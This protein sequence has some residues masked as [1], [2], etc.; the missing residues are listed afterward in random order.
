MKIAFYDTH[1]YEKRVFEE[2]NKGF[3]FDITFFDFHLNED[4]Y[5]TAK[6]FDAVCVF[7]NDVVNQ[8]VIKKLSDCKVKIIA[9]RC[10]GFNNVDLGS[11]TRNGISVVRVPSY[12]PHAIAE[13][14]VGLM[15]SL[16]RK[17][18]Q[19]YIRT[20][21]ANFS[22]EGLVGKELYQKTV[23]IIGT[24]KIGKIV[25]L[26][27]QSFGCNV[28]LYDIYQ[29]FSWADKYNLTY[30][31]LQEVLT[32]SDIITLHCP[33]TE[34][35]KHI[36]NSASINLLKYNC[37]LINTSRGALIDTM[38]LIN[39]LKLKKIAGAALDVYEEESAFFF[40]DWS[41]EILDDDI[42]ARLLTFPNVI[43]TSHQAFLTEE[44]LNAIAE[45]TLEN[46][47]RFD[48][49]NVMENLVLAG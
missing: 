12:S 8:K 5:L 25:A 13:H 35:T 19:A 16:L 32:N 48:K 37:V 30:Y 15:L 36:I 31:P 47:A 11:A 41:D 33:L 38:S 40:T 4:T 1:K 24:G 9:L 44:A 20:R 49:G 29:D 28:M 23:G 45:T 39:A 17:L 43:I 3:N 2:V 21:G 14:T 22:L 6:G 18:P 7:V 42:L 26:I 10:S 34:Q 46:I 27:L